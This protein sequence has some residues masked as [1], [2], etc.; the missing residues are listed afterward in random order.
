MKHLM[1]C[2][3]ALVATVIH[4]SVLAEPVKLD[5][6]AKQITWVVGYAPGGTVDVLTRIAAQQLSAKIDVPV[7]I[8]NRV[9]ASGAIALQAV[10]RSSESDALLITVPGPIIYN[11]P[12][13]QI[14]KQLAPVILMAEG[15]MVIVGG[16]DSPA[17]LKEALA[18]ARRH[19]EKWSYASSGTGT[20]QHLAGELLN[21]VAKT[22]IVHV[23]YKGGAQAATDV[24]GGQ[25][26]MAVL[27]P[28]PVLAH[29]RS[30]ALKAYAVTTKRRLAS[31]PDV[32]ALGEIGFPGY[33]ASQWFA[34]ASS[35]KMPKEVLVKV[36]G[37]LQEIF[38][39]P[40]FKKA[41][42]A[43]GMTIGSGSPTDLVRFIEADTKKWDDLVRKSGISVTE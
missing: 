40:D 17:T 1:R 8:E 13:P 27:G 14:G 35:P 16:K 34:V 36:N 7:V 10:A 22:K 21:Q 29:I 23:P 39:T 42:T 11:R 33:D 32:P 38:Q 31:L 20:S 9:G 30:G 2:A 19:P 24:A 6:P 25:V 4:A 28:T 18:D 43:A 15:P 37:L 5:W 26:P 41:V 12:Q 3:T